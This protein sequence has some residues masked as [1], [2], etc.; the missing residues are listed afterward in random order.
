MNHS[1]TPDQQGVSPGLEP[2]P[3]ALWWQ[4]ALLVAAARFARAPGRRASLVLLRRPGLVARARAVAD[5]LGVG[6]Q[7]AI[8]AAGPL[9]RFE[10]DHWLPAPERG[11]RAPAG[12]P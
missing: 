12:R 3:S 10:S 5:R 9:V 11:E 6:S 4:E 7:V 1:V 2:S 8:G